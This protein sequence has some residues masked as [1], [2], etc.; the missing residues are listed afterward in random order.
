M[1]SKQSRFGMSKNVAGGMLCSWL[2]RGKTVDI[3]R[4]VISNKAH[5]WSVGVAMFVVMDAINSLILKR[6]N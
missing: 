3:P 5:M 6:R 2:V 4:V 1:S